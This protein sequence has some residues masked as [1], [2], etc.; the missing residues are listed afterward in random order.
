MYRNVI[1]SVVAMLAVVGCGGQDDT[2][3]LGQAADSVNAMTAAGAPARA[4]AVF[5]NAEGAEVGTA[6]LTQVG[7]A[8]DVVFHIMPMP[9]GE[10]AVHFHEV[11]ACVAPAF[12]SAGDHFNPGNTFH[13]FEV[14]EGPHA[15]DLRNVMV[16]YSGMAMGDEPNNRVTLL[17]GQPNSL[18]DADGTALILHEGP[19]DYKTQPAGG[20]GARI[21]CGI[22][23]P[24]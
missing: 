11:G 1:G 15:G 24:A 6:E 20:S 7:P 19:D 16:E 2:G 4:R 21:A 22:I 13:G 8:V 5:H 18:L 12:D 17:P 14:A 23:V 3:E 9:P 10:K